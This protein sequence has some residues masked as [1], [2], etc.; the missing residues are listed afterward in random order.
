MT[1]VEL[2]VSLLILGIIG[3]AMVRLLLGESRNVDRIMLQRSARGVTRS[4]VNLLLSELRMA[5]PAGVVA[6]TPTS[7]ELY[8]PYALGISCGKSSGTTV[9]SLLP[10][11]SAVVADA[12]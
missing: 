11:D 1:M 3:A 7:V 12:L 5:L 10:V 9:V 8:A 6:A 2:I 4:S